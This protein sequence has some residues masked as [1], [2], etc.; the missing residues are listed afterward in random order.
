MIWKESFIMPANLSLVSTFLLFVS[1]ALAGGI[2]AKKLKFP[3][4][5]GYIAAGTIVGNLLPEFVDRSLLEV[6]GD[7]G[8]TL[9]L[10]TL[11][12]EFSFVRLRRILGSI[13]WA[14]LAQMVLSIGV[15]LFV[16][17]A[18]GTPFLASLFLSCAAA[19]SSTAVVVKLL[20]EKGQLDTLPG[21]VATGWLIVQDLAVVPILLLLS[22]LSTSGEAD[23]TALRTIVLVGQNLAKAILLLFA[24]SWLGKH[25]VPKL[26]NAVSRLRSQEMFLLTIVGFVFFA[27]LASDLLG[28]TAALGAFL[29]GLIIAETSQNHAVFAEIRPLRDLFSVIFFV[30]FGMGIPGAFLLAFWQKLLGFTALILFVKW[31]FILGLCRFLGYHRKSAF[32]VAISLTQMS[33]FGFILAKEGVALHALRQDDYLFLI[34]I[35]FLTIFV[36]S[37]L[38][39]RTEAL[40]RSFRAIFR[41]IPKFFAEKEDALAQMEGLP[42]SDH[43]VICGYGRVGSYIGRALEMAGIPFVVVDYNQ[44]AVASLKQKGIPVVYGDPADK[45]VLDYAQVDLARGLVIAIP[46]RHTQEMVIGNA[47][48]LNRR[49]KIV[50]RSHHE[51]DQRHLK[52]LGVHTVVQPEFEAALAIV[53]RLLMD[54]GVPPEDISGKIR[55]LKIEHGVG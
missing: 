1:A 20:S 24:A 48:S 14:A 13:A 52:A 46:D 30:S 12:I 23:A 36:S 42:M 35:T 41:R 2:V 7:A 34:S 10:F 25:G 19:L 37:P 15:F 33:E 29:A 9:L 54:F 31:F 28:L 26:L 49:I 18:V 40:Y 3:M 47:Q 27:S 11:G 44:H 39:A 4:I 22:A 17:L 51:E 6:L 38:I 55:R 53:S 50:C 8:V 21:E 16:F 32:A 45:E 5:V 43:V